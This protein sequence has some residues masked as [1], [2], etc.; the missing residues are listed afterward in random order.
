MKLLD[1]AE[2]SDVFVD[3]PEAEEAEP[4]PEP[5]PEKRPAQEGPRPIS[6]PRPGFAGGGAEMRADDSDPG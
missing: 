5:E 6:P 2:E 1:G 4:E 3:E